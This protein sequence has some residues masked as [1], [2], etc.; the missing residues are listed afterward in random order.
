MAI[1]RRRGPRLRPQGV[2]SILF[3]TSCSSLL[4]NSAN[5]LQTEESQR[6]HCIQQQEPHLSHPGYPSETCY[7][8][9]EEAFVVIPN[10]AMLREISAAKKNHHATCLRAKAGRTSRE[11][12]VIV[13][14]HVEFF[15]NMVVS[16]VSRWHK[17]VV[18][19]WESSPR[20]CGSIHVI[21]AKP[22]IMM[23]N[24]LS[25]ESQFIFTIGIFS[26]IALLIR[27]VFEH[28]TSHPEAPVDFLHRASTEDSYGHTS[29]AKESLMKMG[30]SDL[31][32]APPEFKPHPVRL[33]QSSSRHLQAGTVPYCTVYI[34]PGS[35]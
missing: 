30:I 31:G 33:L 11:V 5:T 9:S 34:L 23:E 4:Q 16:I 32:V 17:D 8:T 28:H 2:N 6:W 26:A 10:N 12:T 3:I 18:F 22:S 13:V 25:T 20:G 29:N 35:P 27:Y 24:A 15:G 7:L 19:E 1:P 14:G 21:F